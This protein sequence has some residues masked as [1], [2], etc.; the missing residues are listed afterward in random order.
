MKF[1][2]FPVKTFCSFAISG[3]GFFSGS[4]K[5]KV[6]PVSVQ[7]D[8]G[9]KAL[10]S[11]VKGDALV[12]RFVVLLRAAIAVVLRGCRVTKVIPY[13]VGLVFVFVIDFVLWPTA[14]YVKVGQAVR[15]VFLAVYAYLDSTFF[16][17]GRSSWFSSNRTFGTCNFPCEKAGISIVM[18]DR[19]QVLCCQISV[20]IFVTAFHR[21][22]ITSEGV[23]VK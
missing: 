13:V 15:H 21:R 7:F 2:P 16:A 9:N 4:E 20:R 19:A 14:F 1:S 23:I 11:V 8:S 6:V 10:S 17:L 3:V 12:S 22:L 18:Q 5:A